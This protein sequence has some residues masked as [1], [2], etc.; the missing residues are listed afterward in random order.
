[1]AR[2]QVREI[3]QLFRAE[4]PVVFVTGWMR[5]RHRERARSGLEKALVVP[6]CTADV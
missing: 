5:E 6:V 3:F 2:C 4:G 1:V